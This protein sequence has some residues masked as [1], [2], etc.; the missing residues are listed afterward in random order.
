MPPTNLSE[1]NDEL[2]VILRK[3]R[4]EFLNALETRARV[5]ILKKLHEQYPHSQISDVEDSW[6]DAL[7]SIARM[8]DEKDFIARPVSMAFIVAKRKLIDRFRHRQTILGAGGGGT[9]EDVPQPFDEWPESVRSRTLELLD[10]L[11]NP[12]RVVLSLRF[13]LGWKLREISDALD[14]PVSTVGA[15]VAIGL[16]R[17]RKL[18]NTEI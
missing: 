14:M 13:L 1:L 12:E 17:L 4:G 3:S 18:L 9:L 8:L 6:Q 16:S 2:R 7:L 5:L 15:K 10:E 11:D